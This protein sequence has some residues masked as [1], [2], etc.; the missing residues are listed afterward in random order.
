MKKINVIAAF[1]GIVS[2]NVNNLVKATVDQSQHFMVNIKNSKEHPSDAP[3]TTHIDDTPKTTH[4]DDQIEPVFY[5]PNPL[6]DLNKNFKKQME[7]ISRFIIDPYER[8]LAFK[9]AKE[10]YDKAMI[11]LGQGLSDEQGVLD[12]N[13]TAKKKLSDNV[14]SA[15]QSKDKSTI[16]DQMKA[17][18]DR[19]VASNNLIK[20]KNLEE[21][22]K[23]VDVQA[24]ANQIAQD[25]AHSSGQIAIQQES[26]EN[27]QD[28]N[29]NH[30]KASSDREK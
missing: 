11:A 25:L 14:N 27:S 21:Y 30:N 28:A 16:Q 4:I 3:K 12:K 22:A 29:Q 19:I 7:N 9:S 24:L 5:Q 6:F 10:E 8:G 2:L 18:R 15:P 17:L 13:K 26:I 1:L 23:L 20:N